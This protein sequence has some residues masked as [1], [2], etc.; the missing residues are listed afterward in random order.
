MSHQND[1][2]N[3]CTLRILRVNLTHLRQALQSSLE[4]IMVLLNPP[5]SPAGVNDV[6]ALTDAKERSPTLTPLAYE[7]STDS[8]WANRSCSHQSVSP[9]QLSLQ[10]REREAIETFTHK[11]LHLVISLKQEQARHAEQVLEAQ[12]K[13]LDNL[14][15]LHQK[16]A[17]ELTPLLNIVKKA[18]A[19]QARLEE[20]TIALDQIRSEKESWKKEM[21]AQLASSLRAEMKLKYGRSGCKWSSHS[22]TSINELFEL[23]KE[24]RDKLWDLRLENNFLRSRLL[25]KNYYKNTYSDVISNGMESSSIRRTQAAE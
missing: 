12:K 14:E 16:H 19:L 5:T 11:V 6:S 25:H 10:H 13:S 2:A 8:C 17:E 7:D 22:S 3:L 4:Q 1:Q 24:L 21:A 18:E 15:S 23:V 20:K 9:E